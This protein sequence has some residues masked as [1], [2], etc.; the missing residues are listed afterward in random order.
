MSVAG[1]FPSH[2][3]DDACLTL[4]QDCFHKSGI[5]AHLT[6]V[7]EKDVPVWLWRR[8]PDRDSMASLPEDVRMTGETSAR[9]VFDRVAGAWTYAG[10]K[11][12][13][14]DGEKDA[15]TFFDEIRFM[16]CHRF[17]APDA[18]QLRSAGLYWAYGIAQRDD[19]GCITDYSTG[20]VVRATGEHLPL[21]GTFI[22]GVG[23][24]IAGEGG[25]FDLWQREARVLSCGLDTASNV[26]NMAAGRGGLRSHLHVGDAAADAVLAAGA[27]G[28]KRLV[29]VDAGHADAVGFAESKTA[30]QY[31]RAALASGG[32]LLERQA[33][34]IRDACRQPS[35]KRR[36]G[37]SR[38]PALRLALHGARA[39][40]I[41]LAYADKLARLAAEGD[42][43]GYLALDGGGAV[44]SRYPGAA[45]RNT[46]H[47]VRMTD[48]VIVGSSK[49]RTGAD[50][51]L[52]RV[53]EAAWS[54]GGAG[55]LFESAANLWNTCAASGTIR[56]VAAGADFM[57]LDDSAC[58]R[59]SLNLATFVCGEDDRLF[60]TDGFTAAVRLWTVALDISVA[61]SAMPTPRLAARNWDFR[62]LGLGIAN[63]SGLLMSAGTPY[64][65]ADG[66]AMCATIAALLT[67]TAYAV[68][69][70]MAQEMGGFP[71]FGR[72]RDAMLAV[73]RRHRR[74]A[75]G[76]APFEELCC[77][78]TAL[79]KAARRA[80][81]TAIAA[82]EVSGF[83][84]A[85]VTL[86]SRAGDGGMLTGCDGDGIEPQ[87]A[88]T[89]FERLP[90]GGY[91][92]VINPSVPDA[93]RALGY[94]SDQI[95]EIVRYV[96]GHG[97]LKSA[98]GINHESLRRR[99][100]DEEALER[101]EAALPTALDIRMAFNPWSLGETFCTRMLGFRA[102]DLEDDAFDMLAGLG[103]SNAGI[104][105]ADTYCC[106]ADTLEGA[107]HLRPEH[108]AVFDC[109]YP[110]GAHGTR[111][112]ST[113]SRIAMLA[114]AQPFVSGAVGHRLA[115]PGNASVGDC[116]AA[117]RL[118][119]RLGL[120]ILIL[121]RDDAE[122][123]AWETAALPGAAEFTEASVATAA[124]LVAG[125][126]PDSA[127]VRGGF[128]IYD[129]DLADPGPTARRHVAGS[130]KGA[131]PAD[132]G[133]QSNQP[134]LSPGMSQALAIASATR[135][136]ASRDAAESGASPNNRT[137]SD[138]GEEKTATAAETSRRSSQ[139]AARSAA[140]V[141]S[142]ADAVVEQRQV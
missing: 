97:T 62:P 42:G 111:R 84:N 104:E 55:I 3:P 31:R 49:T 134:A 22:Q 6:Y 1:T 63:L 98:P 94:D 118:A 5:A 53:A 100:F 87:V 69:A 25:I 75:K 124:A 96:L 115:L 38:N 132:D 125:D 45:E 7:P 99:G 109:S 9:Q 110:Q 127:R 64:N 34:A 28:G 14:F 137:C 86:I 17:A 12:G 129:G 40:Q 135:A 21:H 59:A 126:L 122:P 106:G 52:H 103:F 36:A 30:D 39:A 66:R 47:A 85:Q 61:A 16:L 2:W 142:S 11:C 24:D 56:S 91:R 70:E 80:W 117:F 79:E 138:G 19:G 57:F 10:W 101:L 72:N 141:P 102:V 112:L 88:M 139:D 51:L 123:E 60:D 119:W 140:S 92:K 15:R 32:R 107:P 20:T 29:T 23:G 130:E 54:C 82:G 95:G 58:G 8:I 114:A 78:D 108:L 33:G 120:K 76:R 121:D 67:G 116:K 68:S 65:S 44:G 113:A 81:D 128:L 26:S 83:R 71:A 18:S 41:P 27:P 35:P 4:A 105:A 136:L 93:L 131:P 77:P 50:R 13:Y 37:P 74:A 46:R 133:R 73:I 89:Q 90:G 48:E 43:Q